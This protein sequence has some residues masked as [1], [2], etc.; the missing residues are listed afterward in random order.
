MTP[1]GKPRATEVARKALEDVCSG[2]GGNASEYYSELFVDHVNDRHFI[3]LAGV[4]RSV[5]TYKKLFD[6]VKIRVEHQIAQGE[7]VASRF[8]VA[9]I[10][11]GKTVRFNGIAM[12]RFDNGKIVEDWSVTDTFSLLR[13]LGLWRFVVVAFRSFR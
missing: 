12:S 1:A 4:E 10:V 3:G 9:A 8:V 6:Q 7:F 11:K 5:A 13:Q 2:A